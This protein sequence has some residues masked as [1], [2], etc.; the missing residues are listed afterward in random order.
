M[1]TGLTE[2]A[3]RGLEAARVLVDRFVGALDT[4]AGG[5]VSHPSTPTDAE[6]EAR[7]PRVDA[8]GQVWVDLLRTTAEAW[9]GVSP[10]AG[11]GDPSG[12]E[13]GVA[14]GTLLPLSVAAPGDVA[15]GELWLHNRTVAAVE[16][17]RMVPSALRAPSGA[18][19]PERALHLDPAELGSVPA[20]SSRGVTVSVAV[21]HDAPTGRYRGVVL[22]DGLPEVWALLDVR[23]GTP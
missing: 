10:G 20:R 6:A 18:E 16:D 17:V 12:L 3:L 4:A 5:G 7:T 19:I 11:E 9:S 1:D 13:V 22:V 21:P 8:I 15:V 2:I 23:V 14:G